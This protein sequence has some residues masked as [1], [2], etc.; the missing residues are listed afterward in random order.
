MGHFLR[1]EPCPQCG[2]SDALARYADNSAHC[3]SCK[4]NEKVDGVP[5]TEPNKNWT[6]IKGHYADLT[7]RGITEQTCRKCDY[8]IGETATGERVHI[9]LIKNEAGQLIDQKTR[10]KAKNFK[11]LGGSKYKGIIGSWAW[12]SGGKYVALTEGEI[13][14]MSVSQAFENKWSTGSL[15]NGADSVEKA[16]LTDYE[17]LCSFDNIVLCFDNDEPGRKATARACELLP[18]GKVRLMTVPE[19]DPNETL[20][21]HGPAAIAR[22]FWDAKPYRPDGILDG[23]AL[24]RDRIKAH[25]KKGYDIPWPDVNNKLMG[26]RKGEITMLTAG[27]GVGKSSAARALAH[28]FQQVH[29][30]KI[31][32]VYLEENVETT[33]AAYVGL[34]LGI[35]LKSLLANPDMLT[36]DQ[37]DKALEEAVHPGMYMEHFGSLESGRLINKLRY[38]AAAGCD[39][40]ILDHVSIVVSGLDTMDERRDLD[41]LLTKLRSF[42]QETGVGIIAV[43]HLK[44]KPGTPFNEGGQV[45]LSD[46]RGSAALEQLSDTVI[47]FERNQQDEANKHVTTV[48]V[49]KCRITGETG[50][51]DRLKWDVKRGQYEIAGPECFDPTSGSLEDDTAPL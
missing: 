33:A 26:I 22:A 43:A 10:D 21:K 46:L 35:P 51:A 6:P 8:Q 31:G 34:H 27:S 37:W 48:R 16:I 36:D 28:H 49:L 19:K 15:P 11:W 5:T 13:D 2:S 14:R 18:V 3:F 44:R 45:S 29:G 23:S 47:A 32:S 20:Q 30:L 12:P 7:A 25:R 1:H 38:M 9:Q 42:V 39:F 17:K 40:I 50:E 41:V 24:T 4:Y